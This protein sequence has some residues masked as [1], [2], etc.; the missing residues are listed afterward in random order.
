MAITFSKISNVTVGAGGAAS[1][2]FSSIPQIFSDLCIKICARTTNAYFRDSVDVRP[3]GTTSNRNQNFFIAQGTVLAVGPQN[4]VY[5]EI[6]G[7]SDTTAN[8]FGNAEIY[9]PNY[10]STNSNKIFS[11]DAVTENNN[12]ANNALYF[13]SGLWANTAAITSIS[14]VGGGNFMQHSTATLYGIKNS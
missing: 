13:S 11:T 8:I 10:T 3:N 7:N 14:L 12:I 2:V 6:E 1:I 9:I 5:V 4:A